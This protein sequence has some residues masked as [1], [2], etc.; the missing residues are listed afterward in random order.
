VST[1]EVVPTTTIEPERFVDL[2]HLSLRDI[3]DIGQVFV[4]AKFWKDNITAS[5]AI[6]K[7]LAGQELGV[8]PMQAMTQIHVVDGTPRLSAGLIGALVKRSRR[9][10]YRLIEANDS[11]CVLEW[12]DHDFGA[13]P[14]G[15]SEFTM[16]EA[17]AAGLDRAGSGWK[18]YAEDMLFARALTRGARRFAPDVFGGAVYTMNDDVVDEQPDNTRHHPRVNPPLIQ[19]F[20]EEYAN[21]ES[22]PELPPTPSPLDEG[23]K[24]VEDI[25]FGAADSP[26]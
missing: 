2:T 24:S 12:Y 22:E 17:T 6:T 23:Y 19:R 11:I 14:V 26:G 18:K 8:P 21:G 5:Q 1:T 16:K 4:Q 7:I 15:R 3:K 20:D 13:D 25:P 10:N 9:Y